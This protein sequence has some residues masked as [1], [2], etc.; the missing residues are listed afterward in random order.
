MKSWTKIRKEMSP[1]SQA[2]LDKRLKETLATLPLG[3]LRKAR[4]LTQTTMAERLQVD[5][6]S[7]SKLESRTDMY[8]ST[9]REYVE[10]LGGTLELRADFPDGSINIDLH[11]S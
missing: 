5:Q 2:R 11:A 8:L 6:G 9:L 3:K 1:E 10:A 4:S 7:V